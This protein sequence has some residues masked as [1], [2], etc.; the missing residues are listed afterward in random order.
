[1]NMSVY[2]IKTSLSDNTTIGI[3]M[4][5]FYAIIIESCYN[6]VYSVFCLNAY[7]LAVMIWQYLGTLLCHAIDQVCPF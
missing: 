7:S 2:T 1:M 4:F 6:V 5:Q 3:Y